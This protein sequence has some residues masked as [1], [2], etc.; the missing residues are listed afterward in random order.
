VRPALGVEVRVHGLRDLPRDARCD[1][2]PI[3]IRIDQGDVVLDTG[4]FRRLTVT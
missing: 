2:V 1:G 3:A 4:Q